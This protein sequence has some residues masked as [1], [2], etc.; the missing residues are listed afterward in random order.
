MAR[1]RIQRGAVVEGHGF[2]WRTLVAGF[3]KPWTWWIALIHFFGGAAFN[4]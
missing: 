3:K 4:S 1:H 2:Q